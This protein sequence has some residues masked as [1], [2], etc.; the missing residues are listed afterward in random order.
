MDRARGGDEPLLQAQRMLYPPGSD[1]E[2]E[3]FQ[4]MIP[5]RVYNRPS[6]RVLPLA[7][8]VHFPGGRTEAQSCWRGVGGV[9]ADDSLTEPDQKPAGPSHCPCM[10]AL[11]GKEWD[12][13][14]MGW[15]PLLHE[16]P[17]PVVFWLFFHF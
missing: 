7:H 14:G 15:G 16:V 1:R 12:L 5:S 8:S 17:M 2:E 10:E 3:R 4:G 6:L 9:E 13:S 11:Q